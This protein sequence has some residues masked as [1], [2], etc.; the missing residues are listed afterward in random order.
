MNID[1]ALTPSPPN[2]IVAS[3]DAPSRREAGCR[4]AESETFSLSDDGTARL[5]TDTLCSPAVIDPTTKAITSSNIDDALDRELS[6]TFGTAL[7]RTAA[8]RIGTGPQAISVDITANGTP[9]PTGLDPRELARLHQSDPKAHDRL[10]RLDPHDDHTQLQELHQHFTGLP[11][12]LIGPRLQ[13]SKGRRSRTR[14]KKKAL[15][16]PVSPPPRPAPPRP[17]PI[18]EGTDDD[19]WTDEDLNSPASWADP[20]D[21]WDDYWSV[22]GLDYDQLCDP[23]SVYDEDNDT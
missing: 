7:T 16:W 2:K 10:G 8:T 5:S 4:T 9:G 19:D 13:Q 18:P 20:W 21:P 1:P 17:P 23:D 12:P 3:A 22:Y 11:M 15:H 6:S 14:H